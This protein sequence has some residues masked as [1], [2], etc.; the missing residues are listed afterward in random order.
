MA[1]KDKTEN[2]TMQVQTKVSADAYARLEAIGNKYGF[3]IFQLLRMLLD[4]II[5][6]MDDQHNLSEDL[7][8]V[9]RMFDNMRG[10][11]RSICLAADDQELVID[12]VI[13]ILR[14]KDN[15]GK[16]L[17]MVEYKE[18]D[19]PDKVEKFANNTTYNIQTILE[20]VV[21]IINP[22]LYK[23]LR[24]LAVD[25]FNT[26]SVYDT[27]SAIINLYKP[28]DKE[29]E[30]RKEFEDND[31][32]KGAKMHDDVRTKRRHFISKDYFE[33]QQRLF[34]NDN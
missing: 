25:E 5:R 23:H 7:Q 13:Y 19:D 29:D 27:L 26:E 18:C 1:S 8:R 9:I 20:R 16:R 3:S 10:W 11:G 32:H 6:F 12:G 21:E 22:G 34:D 17:V 28:N 4:C 33:G 31:W 2:K 24:M 15:N 14:A 30:F